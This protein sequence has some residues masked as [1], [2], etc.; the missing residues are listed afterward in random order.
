[1]KAVKKEKIVYE[2]EF[3]AYDGTI[4]QDNEECLK[5]E[6]T[7]RCIIKGNYKKLV[8]HSSNTLALFNSSVGNAKYIVDFVKPKNQEEANTIMQMLELFGTNGDRE[9]KLIEEALKNNDYLLILIVPWYNNY[10]YIWD[11]RTNILNTIK[12]NLFFEENKEEK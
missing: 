1:M 7:A 6:N 9:R 12:N 3:V 11:T 10:C 4:F 5:Y 2:T 8:S